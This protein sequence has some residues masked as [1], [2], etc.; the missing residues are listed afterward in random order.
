MIRY[1][2]TWF[3]ILAVLLL[4]GCLSCTSE[5][6]GLTVLAAARDQ[7]GVVPSAPAGWNT[8]FT[9]SFPG[10]AGTAPSSANWFYDIGT[11]LDIGGVDHTTNSTKNV[12]IDGSGHLVLKAVRTTSGKWQSARI[13]ST[14]D[15]FEAPAGGELE[16]RASIKLPATANG[17][18]YWPAFW[19]L[20]SPMRTGGNWPA[21]GEIDM[22]E[23]VNAMNDASQTLHDAA[24]STGH[25]LLACPLSPCLSGYHTYSAIVNRTNT[26]AEYLQFL[27]DGKVVET[28]TEA[29]VGV[30]AW[31]KAI[32]HGFFLVLYL[33]IGG[34]YPNAMCDCTTPTARTASGRTMTVKYVAVYEKGGNST[35]TGKAAATGHITGYKGLCLANANSLDVETNPIILHT[36]HALAGQSWSVYSDRTLRIQGGCLD[37]VAGGMTSGSW[38]DWYPCNNTGDQVWVR[39]SNGE[40][41]NPR[42]GF[43]LADPLGKTSSSIVIEK[44]TD[45]ATQRW[46]NPS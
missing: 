37:D 42:T 41:V 5:A 44:C 32:D 26:K 36:C 22:M 17:L 34:T 10:K 18:G 8:V 2:K 14:R 24:G 7:V 46:S 27:M 30:A 16:M 15:D 23:D 11:S 25:A 13:E 21:S 20:G 29:S 28:I 40:I 19:A 9:D 38:V 4:G 6:T 45:A 33:S 3:S 31:Q 39:R 43:C 35:P 1:S 12:Y